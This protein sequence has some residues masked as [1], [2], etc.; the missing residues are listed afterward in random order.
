MLRYLGGKEKY[1]GACCRTSRDEYKNRKIE[2][3]KQSHEAIV[4]LCGIQLDLVGY[5]LQS[6][7]LYQRCK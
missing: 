6:Q 3:V 4:E 2:H 7:K 5:V 1:A